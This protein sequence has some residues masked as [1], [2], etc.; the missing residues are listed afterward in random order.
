MKPS[1]LQPEQF[2]Q[3][4]PEARK[5]ILAHLDSVRQLPLSFLPNLLREV[6]EYDFKFPAERSAIDNELGAIG[7]LSRE[8]LQI[9]F[10]GFAQISLSPEL[11]Q[12]D[13]INQP[14]RFVELQSAYLWTTLQQDTFRKLAMEYGARLDAS[15]PRVPPALG[16]LGIAIIGKD[17]STYDRP[18]FRNLR[19]HGT[20]F[21]QLKPENGFELLLTAVAARAKAHPVPYGH[22]YI[23]GGAEAEHSPSLTCV[24]YKSLDP[25]RA[26]LLKNMQSEIQRP[27]MGPEELR[28]HLVQLKP[29][30]LGMDPSGDP[31]LNRFQLKLFTEGSGTQIY[32]T[33]FAQ[34]ATREALRRA[35]PLTLLVRFAPRQR[36]RSMNEL[37]S[38]SRATP[39][40]D[41][42][43]SLIDADM[44]AY[45]HWINQRRLPGEAQSVFIA[46]FED[47]QEAIAIAPGLPRGATSP[48]S[49]NLEGLLNLALS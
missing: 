31:V 27:G 46:W 16:R 13:W 47:H 32:S 28:S 22:W 10:S 30:D 42:I 12:F 44:N 4:P 14:A 3:Y 9:W 45:Y 48:S 35:Q 23:D 25:L 37:L 29:S 6:I 21:D 7:S 41:P 11:E 36:Q 39:E 17:V 33:T 49:I 18:L 20:Y 38:M 19:A 8:D 40:L 15:A 2:A 43:G 1:D 34:W 5:V 26:A 24:S